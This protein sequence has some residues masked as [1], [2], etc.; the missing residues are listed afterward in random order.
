MRPTTASAALSREKSRPT[1]ESPRD[2]GS[3]MTWDAN[4]GE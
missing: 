3:G 1:R 2:A 4:T